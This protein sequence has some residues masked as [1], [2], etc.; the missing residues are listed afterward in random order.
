MKGG[1]VLSG[2][3]RVAVCG[4]LTALLLVLQITMAPLPNIELVSPLILLYTLVF[5]T[6]VFFIL[7]PFILLEGMVYGFGMWWFGYLYVWP[8]WAL[9]VR[10]FLRKEQPSV[11]WAAAC[12]AF[13]LAFGALFAIPYA[14]TGGL[15]AGVSYWLAGIPFDLLHCVGNFMLTL[16]LGGPLY[17]VLC[18]LRDRIY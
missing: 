14:L 6:Q 9:V 18:S 17:R 3:R 10:L 15:W 4:L 16:L 7:I 1:P 8:L 11:V 13:G 12:G 5:G 2:A